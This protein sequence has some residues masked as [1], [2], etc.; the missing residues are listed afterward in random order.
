MTPKEAINWVNSLECQEIHF[1]HV[2]HGVANVILNLEDVRIA[3][4]AEVARITE[5]IQDDSPLCKHALRAHRILACSKTSGENDAPTINSIKTQDRAM[6]ERIPRT[7][8]CPHA[9]PYE[10]CDECRSPSSLSEPTGSAHY[11]IVLRT[12]KVP[13][14]KRLQ[15]NAAEQ[16]PMLSELRTLYPDGLLAL[17]DA[18]G[19]EIAVW[20]P[21]DV[22]AMVAAG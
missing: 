3:A 17:V 20:H 14:K 4:L 11:A 16:V 13:I 21:K 6:S 8:K 5:A 2:Y 7:G 15:R 22:E 18:C 19:G 9:L 10:E 12:G 1:K